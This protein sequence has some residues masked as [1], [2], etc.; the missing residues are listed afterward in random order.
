[1]EWLMDSEELKKISQD[2]VGCCTALVLP[3]E[4]RR[5]IH[6]TEDGA[7]LD[8]EVLYYHFEVKQTTS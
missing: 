2:L 3:E 6:F 1:M 8:I 5:I 4:H 7:F